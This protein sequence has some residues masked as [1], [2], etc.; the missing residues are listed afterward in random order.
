MSPVPLTGEIMNINQQTFGRHNSLEDLIEDAKVLHKKLFALSLDVDL[1]KVG[2]DEEDAA[3][4]SS[5]APKGRPKVM[6]KSKSVPGLKRNAVAYN[7][8]RFAITAVLVSVIVAM[9]A[10]GSKNKEN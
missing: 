1:E 8:K 3:V 6:E 5:S 4:A 10:L 2:L 7:C 9:L